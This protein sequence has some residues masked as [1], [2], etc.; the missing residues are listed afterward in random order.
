MSS[1]DHIYCLEINFK[2]VYGEAENINTIVRKGLK[3]DMPEAY[4][5]LDQFKWE[6]ED[7]ESFLLESLD[8]DVEKVAQQWVDEHQEAVAEWTK[9]VDKVDGISVEIPLTPWDSGRA[10]ANI[11]KI[12]LEQQGFEVTLTTVDPA[13]MFEA[14]ASG[15]ADAS[16]A[17]WL[18]IT[19]GAFYEDYKEDIVDLGPNLEGASS[20]LVV[21]SYMEID[22]IEDLKAAE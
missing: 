5:I 1:L 6:L 9:G 7:S 15:D 14:I 11:L 3:E 19:H 20:G 8:A 2:G 12:V 17:A 18:P 21:P 13:V 4:T 10:T 16:T 22:S